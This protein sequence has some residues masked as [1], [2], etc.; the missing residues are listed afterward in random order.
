MTGYPDEP[1]P[2]QI[3]EAATS[4]REDKRFGKVGFANPQRIVSCHPEAK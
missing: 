3:V 4:P 1:P 2:L